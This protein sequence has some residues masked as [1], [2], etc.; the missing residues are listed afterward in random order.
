MEKTINLTLSKS[1]FE[2]LF[3]KIISE[4]DELRVLSD[5]SPIN[6]IKEQLINYEMLTDTLASQYVEGVYHGA[7]YI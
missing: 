2:L 5:K 1:E 7:S 4:R 6:F 3:S